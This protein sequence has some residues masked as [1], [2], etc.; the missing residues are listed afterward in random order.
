VCSY[1]SS[2]LFF[3]LSN[4]KQLP[5]QYDLDLAR[6]AQKR[7]VA[8]NTQYFAQQQQHIQQQHIPL[9]PP[10]SNIM[11]FNPPAYDTL[12]VQGFDLDSALFSSEPQPIEAQEYDLTAIVPPPP[13][14]LPMPISISSPT[15]YI[16][17][18]SSPNS[19]N[20][21]TPQSPQSP[22]QL[23]SN[24]SAD[25][26]NYAQQQTSQPMQLSPCQPELKYLNSLPTI[27]FLPFSLSISLIA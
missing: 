27:T 20:P 6:Q 14:L 16:S 11:M 25:N 7:Q 23:V 9:V 12:S 13:Q 22:P 24:G 4:N 19:S 18:T 8:D 10:P 2:F 26:I 15:E 3:L 5:E 21:A 17:N 1:S